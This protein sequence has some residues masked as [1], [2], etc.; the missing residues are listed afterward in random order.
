MIGLGA[1]LLLGFATSSPH[2]ADRPLADL[3]LEVVGADVVATVMLNFQFIDLVLGTSGDPTVPPTR[4]EVARAEPALKDL[5]GSCNAL[6]ADGVALVSSYRDDFVVAEPLPV[7][8]EAAPLYVRALTQ[9]RFTMAYP[10]AQPV[11]ELSVTWGLY[12]VHPLTAAKDSPM[13]PMKMRAI[14]VR[15]GGA[16]VLEFEKDAPTRSLVIDERHVVAPA[17]EVPTARQA[18][19]AWSWWLVGAAAAAALILLIGVGWLLRGRASLAALLLLPVL[20]ACGP[21]ESVQTATTDAWEV[22]LV[23][24]PDPI[25][26]NEHFTAEVAVRAR[27]DGGPPTSVRV[28]ADMPA[29]GHGMNT[30]PRLSPLGEGRWRVEGLLFHMPG[31]WELYVDVGEGQ[32]LERAAFPVELK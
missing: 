28:D 14:V 2:P 19:E 24:T 13:V 20:A 22:E 7:L 6:S 30:E 31:S 21:G 12:P 18:G 9:V 11:G 4:A 29:H 26:V 8:R 17:A 5:F 10:L 16:V 23:V 1:G 27:A 3:T 25:P 32:A 15:E